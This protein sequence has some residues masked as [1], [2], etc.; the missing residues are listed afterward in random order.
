MKTVE[1]NE[2]GSNET[3]IKSCPWCG[4]TPYTNELSWGG[5]SIRC[6][7]SGC[8]MRPETGWCDSVDEAL[9]TW[10]TRHA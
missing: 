8:R 3:P 1:L 5:V 10:N 6:N 9:T 7:S 2:Q 4:E